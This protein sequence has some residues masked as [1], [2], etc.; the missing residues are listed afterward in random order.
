MEKQVIV[1]TPSVLEPRPLAEFVGIA[2]GFQSK[3]I[4]Q[5]DGKHINAKSIMGVLGLGMDIGKE[6]VISAD[7]ED[8][9]EAIA[10]LAAFLTT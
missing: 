3:T 4:I 6:I 1:R 8:A 9:E 2:N 7:G 5:M 10:A